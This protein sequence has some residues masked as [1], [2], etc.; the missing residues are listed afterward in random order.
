MSTIAGPN[1][2]RD[3]LV[4]ELDAGNIKSYR[5]TG[6]TWNDK[7]GNNYIGVLNNGPTFNTGSLGSLVFDGTDDYG[8]I[9]GSFGTYSNFTVS[10]WININTLL[11]HR[12]IFV[13]KNA[14]DSTDYN[15]NNFAIHTISGGYFG[16]ECNN[17]FGG[18]TSRN[19]TVIYQKTSHCTVV[20]NQS[21]NLVT[22]YLNGVADGTQPITSTVTF[23]DHNLLFLACRQFSATGVNNYQNPLAGTLF[24]YLFYNRALS[25][26]EVLQNYNAVRSRFGL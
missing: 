15:S 3:N 2:V 4:L 1:L 18:N 7:S 22:Y 10:F 14:S 26:S 8:Y 23:N 20:C 5:G 9:T 21:S 19:N 17:L 13:M 12:G 24:N 25:P 6:T 11:N 16:M